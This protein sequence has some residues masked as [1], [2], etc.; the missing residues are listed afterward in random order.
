MH[1]RMV[2]TAP[3]ANFNRKPTLDD[4]DKHLGDKLASSAAD[5][6]AKMKRRQKRLC[7]CNY[8]GP[9]CEFENTCIKVQSIKIIHV[10]YPCYFLIKHDQAACFH[11]I[12]QVG[13]KK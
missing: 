6:E 10:T 2:A 11:A 5:E 8:E 7:F 12:K 1:D 4:D 13:K 9:I 3:M